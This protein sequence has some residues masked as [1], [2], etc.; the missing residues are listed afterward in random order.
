MCPLFALVLAY[1][2]IGRWRYWLCLVFKAVCFALDITGVDITLHMY[3]Y[4]RTCF[5]S[6]STKRRGGYS[7][8]DSLG[9]ALRCPQSRVY[10]G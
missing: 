5:A 10:D 2:G 7:R 9:A 4:T 1:N 6:P 8:G 3:V